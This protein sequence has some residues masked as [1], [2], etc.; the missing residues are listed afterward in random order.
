MRHARIE[1]MKGGQRRDWYMLRHLL[2]R[3]RWFFRKR[4]REGDASSRLALDY[5]GQALAI[6]R[7]LPVCGSAAS[8]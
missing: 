5:V 7:R 2:R 4:T 1:R 6:E 8:F 3:G